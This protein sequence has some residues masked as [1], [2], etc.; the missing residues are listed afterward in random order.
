MGRPT[1]NRIED[2]LDRDR[3]EEF[4]DCVLPMVYGYLWRRSGGCEEVTMGLTEATFL[5]VVQT[6]QSGSPVE[7]PVAWVMTMARRHLADHHQRQGIHEAVRPSLGGSEERLCAA[8]HRE[9]RLVSA[10]ASLPARY[11]L[12]LQLRYVDDWP[13]CQVAD[14][15]NMPLAA[16]ESLIARAR[17]ALTDGYEKQADV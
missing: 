12:V 15:L 2:L 11:Q 6:L 8:R 14:L 5:R 7:E 1:S 17:E 16:T 10:F 13:L 9:A 4:Y 3:F